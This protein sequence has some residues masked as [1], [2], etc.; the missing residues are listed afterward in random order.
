M[1]RDA[2]CGGAAQRRAVVE[3]IACAAPFALVCRASPGDVSGFCV[4]AGACPRGHRGG[5]YAARRV[6]VVCVRRLSTVASFGRCLHLCAA[7]P[8]LVS[9]LALRKDAARRVCR[10]AFSL[11][12]SLGDVFPISKRRFPFTAIQLRSKALG[13]G[14][15]RNP[16]AYGLTSGHSLQCSPRS[17][18][19]I[20]SARVGEDVCFACEF[21]TPAG[22]TADWLVL[23]EAYFTKACDSRESHVARYDRCFR[24]RSP[25]TLLC[26][27]ESQQTARAAPMRSGVASAATGR[28]SSSSVPPPAALTSPPCPLVPRTASCIASCYTSRLPQSVTPSRPRHQT[29]LRPSAATAG[30]S[31]SAA[32]T[33]AASSAARWRGSE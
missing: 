3:W 11:V 8:V 24:P 15:S 2:V 29:L 23:S 30:T 28:P 32:A 31:S 5:A 1:L 22:T 21:F 12:A 17:R 26:S 25:P 19:T 7:L 6:C 27:S 9:E 33:A 4:A 16:M 18:K 10:D 20:C 14:V 13:R